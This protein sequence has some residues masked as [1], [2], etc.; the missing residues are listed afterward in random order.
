[1]QNVRYNYTCFCPFTK[2]HIQNRTA[3]TIDIRRGDQKVIVNLFAQ[4]VPGKLEWKPYAYGKLTREETQ[5]IREKWF[6]E[7]LTKLTELDLKKE[8]IAIP[9]QIGCG[10]AGGVWKN[11][12][13]HIEDFAK[14]TGVDVTIYRLPSS[15]SSSGGGGG[16]TTTTTSTTKKV[17]GKKR[18]LESFWNKSTTTTKKKRRKEEDKNIIVKE[19]KDVIVIEDDGDGD[20]DENNV[21]VID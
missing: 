15:S 6:V 9:Y 19:D 5:K 12:R 1:M 3:G 11:Y 20:D 2:H 4:D 21:I 18:T 10:L 14:R 16:G 17:E 8:S 7:A 13:R